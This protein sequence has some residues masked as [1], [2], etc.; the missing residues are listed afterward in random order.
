MRYLHHLIIY[1][2]SHSIIL[3]LSCRINTMPTIS[4]H[5]H[6]IAKIVISL[7]I[8]KTIKHDGQI[9]LCF[10]H[11]KMTFYIDIY[12]IYINNPRQIICFQLIKIV[13]NDLSWI[14]HEN[15][16]HTSFF[17]ILAH[18]STILYWTFYILPNGIEFCVVIA[19]ILKSQW[20]FFLKYETF[21]YATI[22]IYVDW[23]NLTTLRPD[24]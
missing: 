22:N 6:L 8:Y 2:L 19:I 10:L 3:S 11:M 16:Y 24:N 7:H 1:T 21:D 5:P 15:M 12:A 23:Y 17:Y 4:L 9:C 18:S 14:C 20:L 13:Y